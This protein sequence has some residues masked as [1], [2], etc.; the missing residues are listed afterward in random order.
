MYH[1]KA[2]LGH[3]LRI[4]VVDDYSSYIYLEISSTNFSK[5]LK[6]SSGFKPST[7]FTIYLT[8]NCIILIIFLVT[9]KRFYFCFIIL[10]SVMSVVFLY[11]ITCLIIP[12]RVLLDKHIIVSL[13]HLCVNWI[14]ILSF[15]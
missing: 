13:V 4:I 3:L 9:Y 11:I 1:N 2:V 14:Y 8:F 10:K 15:L 12:A 5:C 7:Y 6:M